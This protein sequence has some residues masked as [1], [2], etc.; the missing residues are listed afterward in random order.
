[1]FKYLLS[2]KTAA[3]MTLLSF[4]LI[5]ILPYIIKKDDYAFYYIGEFLSVMFIILQGYCIAHVYTFDERLK[6]ARLKGWI[7]GANKTSDAMTRLLNLYFTYNSAI[8]ES[9]NEESRK[10]F[11]EKLRETYL[12]QAKDLSDHLEKEYGIK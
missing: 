11:T 6:L 10:I 1:M 4:S 12:E 8:P 5:C 7:E 9:N 2:K 3:I